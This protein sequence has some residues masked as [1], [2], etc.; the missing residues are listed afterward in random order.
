M[1][2][3]IPRVIPRMLS[4]ISRR[5]EIHP[6]WIFL[7]W[8]QVSADNFE[9]SVSV[10]DVLGK[11]SKEGVL[12]T[13]GGFFKFTKNNYSRDGRTHWYTCCQKKSHGCTAR[14]IIKRE[15][16]TGEDGEQY[17]KNE[18]VEVSTPEVL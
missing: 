16:F 9:D 1:T 5:R 7:S 3:L 8:R 13:H 6:R 15:E 2:P 4:S 14:A 10:T 11:S 17:V 12:I 18:L